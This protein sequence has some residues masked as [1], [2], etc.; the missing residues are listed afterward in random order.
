MTGAPAG[1]STRAIVI[2]AHGRPD[3]LQMDTVALAPPGPGELRIRQT[4]IGVNYHD[5]Y[6]RSGSYQTLSLP[7]VPGLEG[8]GVVEQLGEGV[9]D[10]AIGDRIAYTDNK[11]GGYSAARNIPAAQAV[12]VPDG[13]DDVTAAAAFLKGMTAVALADSVHPLSAGMTI[14]V[15]AAAGGV[16]R[17]LTQL[18]KARGCRVIGTVGSSSKVES[19]RTAG[20][21]EIVLYREEDV[22]ARVAQLTAG[23]GVEVVFDAVGADTF[24]GSLGALGVRGHI[25][26]YGQ[27][28]GP[29]P[30][31]ELSRLGAKS[32]SVTR[33]FLWAYV[34]T[35]AQLRS[36]AAALFAAIADGELKVEMGGTYPLA[37]AAGAH[38][39]LEA[40]RAGPFV[41]IP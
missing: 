40:R 23:R 22:A 35:P 10:F 21:D 9:T 16:G 34:S 25:V 24:E 41:L 12:P 2:A 28:S 11:Y 39:D 6:V 26:L 19:A 30:P 13:V 1:E 38:R 8:A 36:V 32:A 4:A 27:A 7:G 29:V 17:L 31:F 14:L 15:H 18:A 37:D 3:V 20:C 33:P 5:V